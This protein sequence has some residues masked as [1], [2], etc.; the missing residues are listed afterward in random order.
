MRLLTLIAGLLF[1]TLLMAVETQQARVQ[2][3]VVASKLDHPWGLDF[4]ADGRLL[5][6]ERSGQL[7]TVS[8]GKVSDPIQGLPEIWVGGQGGRP[9]WTAGR[10]GVSR[11]DLLQLL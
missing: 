7:R 11:L 5:V 1:A 2:V 6:S 9:G 10:G 8:S 3:E 4:L